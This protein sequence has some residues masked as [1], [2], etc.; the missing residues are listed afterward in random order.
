MIILC[1]KSKI[2]ILILFLLVMGHPIV[3][4]SPTD[5]YSFSLDSNEYRSFPLITNSTFS[6]LK[7]SLSC[8][9]C[10]VSMYVLNETN[11]ELFYSGGE[12]KSL[13]YEE[14]IDNID[15]D[16]ELGLNI[17]YYVVIYNKD[18]NPAYDIILSLD[19]AERSA[20]NRSNIFVISIIVFGNLFAFLLVVYQYQAKKNIV[21]LSETKKN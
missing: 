3:A 13:I 21:N 7:I 20:N 19:L 4:A 11:F 16:L 2:T 14:N 17:L 10:K 15:L 9:E 1:Y 8:N 5:S 12:L 18:I 6:S